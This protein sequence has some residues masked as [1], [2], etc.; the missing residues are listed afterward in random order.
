MNKNIFQKSLFGWYAKNARDLPWR[1]TRDPYKIWISEIMLQQTTVNTV[2]PYYE[3]WIKIFPDI[4]VLARASQAKILK[5]WQGL[6]YYQRARNI[7]RSA[8]II[9]AQYGGRIPEDPIALRKL[10]GF[11]PY[12]VAS[13]L[14]IAFDQRRP[15]VD[16]NVRRVVM[17]LMALKGFS[18][19]KKDK[20]IL[21]FL[22]KVLPEKNN[23]IFN[24]A[25]MELGA[26]VCR[27]QQPQC[28]ACPFERLCLATKK[29]LQD[30]IPAF[31]RKIAQKIEAVCALIEKDGRY[32]IQKRPSRGLLADLWEFPGGKIERRETQKEALARELQEEIGARLISGDYLLSIK[33]AY[34]KFKVH[35]HVWRC[36]VEPRP[37]SDATHKWVR[38]SEFKNF[39]LPSA[40]ARIIDKVF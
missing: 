8:E 26:L 5:N 32:F 39:P 35:L 14:S 37:K 36:V 22:D 33:H 29:N 24:Q 3:R 31:Q 34:T 16:A 38:V 7:K 21:E 23:N 10:P 25:L 11:G 27:A 9:C 28:L 6:G 13:V 2:I 40:T 4:K 15:L 20:E 12:T 18:E 17:R 19:T 30:S 1:K